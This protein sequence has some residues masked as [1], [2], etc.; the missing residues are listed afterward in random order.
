MKPRRDSLIALC[1]CNNFFVSCERLFRPELR[2][3]PVVVLSSNDGCIVSR[4]NEVKAMGI[5]MGEPYFKV[6]ALLARK[7][8]AVFSGN[9][10]L[11][12]E[13]SSRV[14]RILAAFTDKIEI[15]SI[16]EAFLNLA[17]ASV[18]DP[19]AYAAKIRRTVGRWAG[20]PLSVGIAATKTLSKL[21][22][23]RAKRSPDGVV[24]LRE[25]GVIAHALEEARVEDVWGVGPRSAC[26]LRGY[27][28]RTALDLA[29]RDLGWVRK[30]LSVRGV[31]TALELRGYPC[32][33]PVAP[34]KAPQSIQVSRSFGRELFTVE[35]LSCPVVEH[36]LG[37]GA[38]LRADGLAAKALEV[39]I[40]WGYHGGAYQYLSGDASFDEPI[41]SDQELIRAALTL[42]PRIYRSG[43]NYTKAGVTLTGLCDA[44]HRQRSLFADTAE[45]DKLERLS[46][47]SDMINDKFGGRAIYPA[48]LAGD[49]GNWHARGSNRS[50]FSIRDLSRLPVIV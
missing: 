34:A 49:D 37:A 18:D 13:I 30:K 3:R 1:D 9:L 46:A 24:A 15:Y 32:V 4:S 12:G 16:D 5:P 50:T 20:V 44:T 27:G 11:Y 8:V 36:I 45:R 6:K 25:P 2:S 41:C 31:M 42:L 14:M 28:V 48:L 38:R 23:E 26:L 39:S 10:A 47:V 29:N 17:I 22:S 21:A 19:L 33:E 43:K 7:G 40:R 35:E